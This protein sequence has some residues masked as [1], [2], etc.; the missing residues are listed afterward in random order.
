MLYLSRRCNP[1]VTS[2]TSILDMRVVVHSDAT[3]ECAQCIVWNVTRMLQDGIGIHGPFVGLSVIGICRPIV[4]IVYKF[5]A[6]SYESGWKNETI[7][8]LIHLYYFSQSSRL[9]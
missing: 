2:V 3:R 4:F 1:S 9:S 8:F 7:M 5:L 6:G